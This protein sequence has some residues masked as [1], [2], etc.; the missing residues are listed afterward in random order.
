MEELIL[1]DIEKAQIM[2]Q[3]EESERR[4]SDRKLMQN[5]RANGGHYLKQ[6]AEEA[7]NC[8]HCPYTKG[9]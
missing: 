3:R 1:T 5:C 2:R 8:T 4:D 9:D 6:V 7:F